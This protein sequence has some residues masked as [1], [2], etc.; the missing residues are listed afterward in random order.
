MTAGGRTLFW[1]TLFSLWSV[2]AQVQ[3]QIFPYQGEERI[4]YL[5]L[6]DSLMANPPLIFVLHGYSGSAASI[7]GYTGLNQLA[8]DNSFAV[9]YP[10]G[11][12]DDWDYNFWNVGYAFHENETVDD[13]GFLSSLAQYL[14][15]EYSLSPYNTFSIGMSNG[16]EMSY[17]LACQANDI[18]KAIASVAGMMMEEIYNTC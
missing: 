6:P 15:A 5:Y 11:S 14:Q 9:Y 18:F 1:I 8:E 12:S 7:M 16:G 10:R 3:L 13:V 2:Q 17:M 4:Y